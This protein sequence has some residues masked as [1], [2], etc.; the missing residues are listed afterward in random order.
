MNAIEVHFDDRAARIWQVI[1]PSTESLLDEGESADPDVCVTLPEGDGA[2]RVQIA[3]A[4]DRS[5]F[6]FVDAQVT[7]GRLIAQEPRKT[8]AGA[9]NRQRF[10]RAVPKAFAYPVRSLARNHKLMTSMVRRDI[11]ARYR[12]SFG[13]SL[14]PLFS[15]RD[16]AVA[17]VFRSRGTLARDHAGISQLCEE[18]GIPAGNPA[19]EPGDFR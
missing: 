7:N 2:Y 12:G 8:S 13:G 3:S 11:L 4:N 6:T 1:D 19:D 5:R 15:R 10:F 16:P 14:C 9:M 18:A 17:G